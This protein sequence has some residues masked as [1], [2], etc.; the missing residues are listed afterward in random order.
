M[1]IFEPIKVGNMELKNRIA[2]PAVHHSYTPDGF[3]NERLLEYYRVRALGGAG[4]ITI[5]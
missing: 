3:V 4:L 1:K 2:M 5:G